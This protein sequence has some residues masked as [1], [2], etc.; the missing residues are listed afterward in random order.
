V[1]ITRFPATRQA[2]HDPEKWEP[3]SRLRE[4]PG[5]NYRLA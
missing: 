5:T 2:A 4:A 1:S 3:V